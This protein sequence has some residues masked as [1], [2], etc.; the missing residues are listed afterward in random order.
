MTIKA[1]Q[2]KAKELTS[3]QLKT[4]IDSTKQ[5]VSLLPSE[6]LVSAYFKQT[7]NDHAEQILAELTRLSDLEQKRANFALTHMSTLDFSSVISTAVYQKDAE[8]NMQIESSA[9]LNNAIERASKLVSSELIREIKVLSGADTL[10]TLTQTQIDFYSVTK[11]H[12][13]IIV[14]IEGSKIKFAPVF[15]RDLV[16]TQEQHD[17]FERDAYKNRAQRLIKH[18]LTM[19]ERKA[20]VDNSWIAYLKEQKLTLSQLKAIQINELD[21]R[22]E[23]LNHICDVL[24]DNMS[25]FSRDSKLGINVKIS[26]IYYN[27]ADATKAQ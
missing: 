3:K 6:D 17:R 26:K 12:N 11:K 25:K 13:K 24:N 7:H 27:S 18:T 23:F 2:A 16:A 1:D 19:L 4:I 15:L 22:D 21:R 5:F 9:Q 20:L 14:E 10:S 8:L